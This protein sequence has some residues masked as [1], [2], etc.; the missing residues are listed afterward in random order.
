MAC[1]VTPQRTQ[2]PDDEADKDIEEYAEEGIEEVP[3]VMDWDHEPIIHT[4]GSPPK[5][6]GSIPPPLQYLCLQ[7]SRK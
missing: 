5:A 7:P 1:M 3:V 6:T 4:I 2:T